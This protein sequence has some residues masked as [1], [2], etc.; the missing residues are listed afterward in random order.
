M[1]STQGTELGD[2]HAPQPLCTGTSDVSPN[3]SLLEVTDPPR[4]TNDACRQTRGAEAG[5]L[6][7]KGDTTKSRQTQ[8]H[9][10]SP[11]Q[12]SVRDDDTMDNMKASIS[13][14]DILKPEDPTANPKRPKKMRYDKSPLPPQERTRSMSRRVAH[15]DG[16]G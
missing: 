1:D 16:E 5:P 12:T 13:Q 4:E 6:P 9:P 15:K 11:S 7:G 2:P 3:P 10:L 14:H 8:C